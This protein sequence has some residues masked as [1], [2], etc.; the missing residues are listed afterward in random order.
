MAPVSGLDDQASTV[1]GLVQAGFNFPENQSSESPKASDCLLILYISDFYTLAALCV[2]FS[3][4]ACLA[5]VLDGD[6]Q[7]QV[8]AMELP[9]NPEGSYDESMCFELTYKPTGADHA[10]EDL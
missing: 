5:A 1:T 10:D 7:V 4:S 2:S 3:P 9:F 6:W 8:T